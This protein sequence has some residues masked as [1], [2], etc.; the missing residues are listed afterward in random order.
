M[1]LR[2]RASRWLARTRPWAAV[3]YANSIIMTA[4]LWHQ[5]ALFASAGA[6]LPLGFPQPATGSAAWWVLRPVWLALLGAVLAGLVLAFG[7][8]ER[9]GRRE[10][11]AGGARRAA[12][13][14]GTVY[15]LTGVLGFAVSGFHGFAASEGPRLVAF[16]VNPLQNVVHLVAGWVL[17][18]AAVQPAPAALRWVRGGSAGL[19]ALGAAGV[20][21]AARGAPVNVLAADLPGSFLHVATGAALLVVGGFRRRAAGA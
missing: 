18:R 4:F 12:A 11:P 16:Q 19:V 1:L 13:L 14:L 7:R 21:L 2:A 15:T 20:W 10:E 8:F 9:G 5:T 3:I 6:L 17:L